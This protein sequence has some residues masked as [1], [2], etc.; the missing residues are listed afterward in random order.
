MAAAA[1]IVFSIG[2]LLIIES[3]RKYVQLPTFNKEQAALAAELMKR[4]NLRLVYNLLVVLLSN[5]DFQVK[6]KEP[7]AEIVLAMSGREV[8]ANDLL[9]MQFPE[10]MLSQSGDHTVLNPVCSEFL[11]ALK[12][13]L[14]RKFTRPNELTVLRGS[15]TPQEYNY[16]RFAEGLKDDIMANKEIEAKGVNARFTLVQIVQHDSDCYKQL[17][18]ED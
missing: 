15:L 7:N 10:E 8:A 11:E 12:V 13:A 9:T 1:K 16:L 14:S 18:Q 5:S 3:K 6:D 2:R 4:Q 17:E